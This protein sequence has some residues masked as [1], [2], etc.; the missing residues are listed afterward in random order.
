LARELDRSPHTLS[1]GQQQRLA[2][3]R[4][5]ARQP[6]VLLLD[7]PFSQLDAGLRSELRHELRLLQ[8]KL[9]A[10]VIY[11]THDQ[12][13]AMTLA[14]QLAVIDHGALQQTGSPSQLYD[15]PHNRF[16]A[17]FLG[18]PSMRFVDGH[19][20]SHSGMITWE[21]ILGS[22][23]AP[24]HWQYKAGRGNT[25]CVLGL[26]P[27]DLLL[28]STSAA[29]ARTMMKVVL[30]EMLGYA[31]LVTLERQGWQATARVTSQIRPA[32]GDVVPVAVQMEKAH[33]FDST[34]KAL[35]FAEST[36]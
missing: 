12:E 14:D 29:P 22:L 13:E 36:A 35:K 15:C 20:S 21:S 17:G 5:L 16:I 31:N 9:G 25:P 34:G 27:D 6:D 18:W 1:G 23:P 30:V 4:A 32:P 3:G 7:E 24:T 8:R 2:L 19:L 33:L 28:E 26:R 10:T 11:V